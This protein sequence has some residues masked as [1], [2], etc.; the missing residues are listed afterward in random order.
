[1]DIR[2]GVKTRYH[3]SAGVNGNNSAVPIVENH[4]RYLTMDTCSLMELG[5]D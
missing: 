4:E 1:M 3:Y 5:I 2:S